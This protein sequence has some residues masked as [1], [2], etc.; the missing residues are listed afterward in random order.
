MHATRQHVLDQAFEGSHVKRVAVA[1]RSDERGENTGERRGEWRGHRLD[2]LPIHVTLVKPASI[3]TPFIEHARNYMPEA[4]TFP[5]PVYAPDVVA[6]A[7]LRCAERRVREITVGGSGRMIAAI[8]RLAPRTTD[9]LM[10]RTLYDQQKDKT[11]K[12]QSLDSLYRPTRDGLAMGPY[13]G[14]VRRTSLSTGTV[15]S[16][17]TR[18]LPFLAA[19][20]VLAASARWNT[21]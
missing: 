14:P 4:P 9:V 1:E 12:I 11:G 10:E 16:N 13:D 17:L 7:I 2:G 6:R 5:P 18:A 3:N 21:E 8:G 15:L 20:A 19:G